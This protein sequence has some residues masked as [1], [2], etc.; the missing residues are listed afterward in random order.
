MR[1]LSAVTYAPVA[2][3]QASDPNLTTPSHRSTNPTANS[4]PKGW[5]LVD[6]EPSLM[7]QLSAMMCIRTADPNP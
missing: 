6:E 1:Q 7:A 3:H 4:V 2:D 5:V